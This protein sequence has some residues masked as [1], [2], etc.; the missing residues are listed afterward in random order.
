MTREKTYHG[1]PGRLSGAAVAT[2][3][4]ELGPLVAIRVHLLDL[5]QL[6]GVVHVAGGLDW[7]AAKAAGGFVGAIKLAL[8]HVPARRLRTE[9][10]LG[11][12]DQGRDRG[13]AQH[14]APLRVLAEEIGVLE[15]NRGDVSQANTEGGP[16]LPHHGE[17]AANVLRGRFGGVDGRGG[18]LGA[19]GE[20]KGKTGDQQVGKGVGGSHPEASD[21]R[22]EAGDEDGETTSTNL[23]KDGVGPAPDQG[24][25]GVGGTVEETLKQRGVLDLE[26][27]VVELLGTVDSSLI[28]AL[29]D[30][31]TS[32]ERAEE[33]QTPGLVPLVGLLATENYLLLF[34]DG[35]DVLEGAVG[36]GD[37]GEQSTLAEVL[38][39]LIETLL[40]AEG[41]DVGEDLLGGQTGERVA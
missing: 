37:L 28:H 20:T 23:V 39:V 7:D 13:R 38:A 8:F 22:N 33:V 6:V 32:A 21:N 10:D 18:G 27:L 36:V 40:L 30:G 25:T 9:V 24:R 12:D 11:H 3:G 29:D 35:I 26:R 41:V 16:H 14:P 19:D 34:A 15:S 17:G 31:R 5:E 2:D 1:E 4:K